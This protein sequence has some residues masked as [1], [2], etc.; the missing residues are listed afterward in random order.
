MYT[1]NVFNIPQE[2]NKTKKKHRRG[3]E[4]EEEEKES[5]LGKKF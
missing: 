3:R 2:K 5:I 1:R 4:L